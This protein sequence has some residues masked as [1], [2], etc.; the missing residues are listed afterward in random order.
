MLATLQADDDESW[1]RLS[2][3]MF[4]RPFIWFSLMTGLCVLFLGLPLLVISNAV[5]EALNYCFS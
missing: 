4:D 3:I 1:L 2:D 5:V